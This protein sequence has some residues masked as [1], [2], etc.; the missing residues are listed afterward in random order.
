MV[1]LTVEEMGVNELRESFHHWVRTLRIPII[2]EDLGEPLPHE[3]ASALRAADGPL[4]KGDILLAR[5]LWAN[6]SRD[7]TDMVG[8]MARDL[9]ARLEAALDTEYA[10]ARKDEQERYQSRQGELSVLIQQTTLQRL[11]REIAELKVQREQGVLFNFGQQL[12]DIDASIRL[13]EDE[14]KRRQEHFEDLRKQLDRERRRVIDFLLPRRYALRG[15]AQVF[16]VTVE[17]RLPEVTR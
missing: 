7:V 12:T 13:K 6:V 16:P 5:E 15:Q 11:E 1:L 3:P 4:A 17:I 14:V 10:T 8:A 9:T 2:G